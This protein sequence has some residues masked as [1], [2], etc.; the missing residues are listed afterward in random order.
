MPPPHRRRRALV[1][2]AASAILVG[3]RSTPAGAAPAAPSAPSAPTLA[4]QT[5]SDVLLALGDTG[6]TVAAWQRQLNV[7]A[8]KG[9]TVDAIFGPSTELATLDFQRFFGLT[10]TGHVDAR[11]RDVM[12]LVIAVQRDYTPLVNYMAF[13]AAGYPR[14]PSYCL[15]LLAH[16]PSAWSVECTIPS[17]QP[18]DVQVAA[19]DHP[20]DFGSVVFGTA[21]PVISQV[22]LDLSS[23]GSVSADLDRN[24]SG[25]PR[26]VWVSPAPADDIAVIR[27]LGA[28]GSEVRRV[29]VDG[30]D[31]FLVLELGDRGPAVLHWQR[32]LNAVASVGL[33]EDGVFGW[34]TVQAT[35]NL[36]RFFG[37]SDDGIVGPE[38]RQLMDQLLAAL[39]ESD[40]SL[41]AVGEPLT[42]D[43]TTVGFPGEL[44]AALL[45]DVRLGGHDGFDR[46][47]F[48][49]G[50][51]APEARFRFVE[52]P[53][54]ERP[55]NRPVEVEGE[56][57]LEVT[58]SRASTVDLTGEEPVI[59]YPGPDRI[60]APGTGLV[61]EVV[62]VGDF[63]NRVAWIIGLDAD[64]AYGFETFADPAR[65]VIDVRVPK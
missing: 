47:V 42:G 18:I 48:E 7:A 16:P 20:A 6:P 11:T 56:L 44:P 39:A 52:E 28:D 33:V 58:M 59:V 4:L 40:G 10:P 34:R 41:Q 31:T 64:A 43:F 17:R 9:L 23:G 37:L 15:E 46:L 2:A 24:P 5:E 50:E 38:T 1:A 61:T 30:D 45:E 19:F 53:L 3:G 36:Q 32:Q 65:L 14:G 55:S 54:R 57:F 63:E 60:S 22:Q 8:A 27:A 25:L 35:A 51:K 62:K 12:R 21:D 26:S 29:V 13:E 49:F